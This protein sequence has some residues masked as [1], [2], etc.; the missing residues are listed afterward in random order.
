MIMT[1]LLSKLSGVSQK[2]SLNYE[3]SVIQMNCWNLRVDNFTELD[4]YGGFCKAECLTKC[5]LRGNGDWRF[6]IGS[7]SESSYI[8]HRHVAAPL[9]Q[10]GPTCCHLLSPA[11][12]PIT[13]PTRLLS[14]PF[15]SL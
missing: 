9:S 3:G 14:L 6:P 13:P 15:S 11:S 2:T 10:V 5:L 8:R 4:E 1:T 7:F 12:I